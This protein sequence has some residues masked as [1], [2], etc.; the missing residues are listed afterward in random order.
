MIQIREEVPADAPVIADL[1]RL[2][3]GARATH[4]PAARMRAGTRPV[5]GLC[6][7]AANGTGEIVG[8]LRF[9]PVRVG[10]TPALQLGPLAVRPER[11]GEGFGKALVREG[12]VLARAGGHRVLVL[13]GDPAYYRPF[14]FAPA[15]P[16][17]IRLPDPDDEDR[18]QVLEL[19]PGALAGVA[20]TVRPAS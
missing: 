13:I 20:G 17:G 16:R 8:T 2:A 14:G 4:S 18:L 5:G 1:V 9:W 15:V 7:V 12:I 6:L 10:T 3:L 11:R 19:E